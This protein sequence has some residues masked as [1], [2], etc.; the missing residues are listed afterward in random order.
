MLARVLA[1]WL[2][3]QHRPWSARNRPRR[4]GTLIAVLALVLLTL[5]AVAPQRA[6]ARSV[7][8]GPVLTRSTVDRPDD[9]RKKQIH[10]MYV[11]PSDRLD[12]ALDVDGTVQNTVSSFQGWLANKTRGR[13]LRVD[14]FQG[15]LDITFVRLSRTDAEIASLGAFVRDQVESD[16]TA[17]G[18][19]AP[20]KVYA[21]YYDGT[22]DSACGGA[23][24][25][26]TLPGRVVALYLNGLPG[27][28]VPCASNP[29]AAAG[30]AP[31]YLEFAMLHEILHILGFVP[32]C[33]PNQWRAGHVS[34]NPDDLMWAGDGPWVPDGWA[35]V[36]LDSGNDDYYHARIRGCPDL[37]RSPFLSKH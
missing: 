2:P 23:A 5:T 22:S 33:A 14:T 18:F 29:F 25:P 27:G 17:A 36:V 7:A 31:T 30:A 13:R 32:T 24:W 20:N 16:L 1:T 21:V 6:S 12:R 26:P 34:D 28:P 37:A 9:S 15:S 35:N 8:Y 4:L 10:F 19:T 3:A 11:V